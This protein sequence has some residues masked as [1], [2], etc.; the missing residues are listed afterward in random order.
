MDCNTVIGDAMSIK[1]VLSAV[2][3]LPDEQTD[4]Q[5]ETSFEAS[6]PDNLDPT[7][8]RLDTV[9]TEERIKDGTR[10]D[11]LIVSQNGKA[12]L[13]RAYIV[14]WLRS[15][16]IVYDH[17]T[18]Y[19]Y[20]GMV[21]E[22]I[23][24]DDVARMIYDKVAS[25]SEAPF[26]TRNTIK[27][28]INQV[29]CTST[30]EALFERYMELQSYDCEV[31]SEKNPNPYYDGDLIP[32]TNGL[33]SVEHDE[34]YPYSPHLFFD[35]MYSARY[36]PTIQSHP[37]ESVY[38]H[39][40]PNDNTRRFFFQMCGYIMFH[41]KMS[42]P[43]IFLIYGPGETG[44][45]ALQM[46]LTSAIGQD[47]VSVLSLDQLSGQFGLESLIGKVLNVCGETGSG[48]RELSKADGELL[49]RLSDG[50]KVQIDRKYLSKL[51]IYNTA[52]LMFVSNTLPD[53][54]DT[55]SGLYRRLFIIPCRHKQNWNDQIYNKL[56]E[57]TALSW[58]VN[59]SLIGYHEFLDNGCKFNI[60]KEMDVEMR[61]YMRQDGLNDF[62]EFY[63][64]KN[65][66]DTLRNL[67]DGEFVGALYESY[68][69]YI[70]DVGGKP[71]SQRKFSEKLR[72]EYNLETVNKYVRKE[73][74][75]ATNLRIFRR[76]EE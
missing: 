24:D 69:D 15:C 75:R 68:K 34:L 37:V 35:R 7:V 21:Y 43:S 48:Y 66:K 33:Y 17:D 12:S 56:Q 49:K 51:E 32:F 65:D 6:I 59:R 53:F 58:L 60:S 11:F 3:S 1:E 18:P 27:D 39:I 72:N 52:K 38:K 4:E 14:D 47:N 61:H 22:P 9:S 41:P 50:Q 10:Q 25:R 2:D 19:Q 55:S 46:A 40:I 42:P 26:V 74:G 5:T 36:D 62:L 57:P 45:T 8:G 54:G 30:P 28:I 73:D 64:G 76:L 44:K 29:R 31:W 20:N 16:R 63:F 23:T 67:I 13:D 70:K 71:M